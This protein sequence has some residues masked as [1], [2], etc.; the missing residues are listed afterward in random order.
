MWPLTV[1][2]QFPESRST[3]LHTPEEG[4]RAPVSYYYKIKTLRRT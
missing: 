2:V 4:R 1:G 3:A